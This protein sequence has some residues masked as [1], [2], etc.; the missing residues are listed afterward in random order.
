MV[1]MVKQMITSVIS[2]GSFFFLIRSAKIYLF[3]KIPSSAAAF[4]LGT[5]SSSGMGVKVRTSSLA[6]VLSQGYTLKFPDP[7]FPPQTNPIRTPR[8]WALDHS[9]FP[10]P[11]GNPP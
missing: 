2:R 9:C 8:N 10:A 3:T 11:R 1:T 6:V 5:V 4:L 7:R